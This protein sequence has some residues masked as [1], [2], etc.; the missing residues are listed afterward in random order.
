MVMGLVLLR[1]E[2]LKKEVHSFLKWWDAQKNFGNDY[3][4]HYF[5]HE[6]KKTGIGVNL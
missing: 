4:V 6:D 5:K 3:E 1:L 2:E